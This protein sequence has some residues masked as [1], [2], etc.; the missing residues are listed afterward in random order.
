MSVSPNDSRRSEWHAFLKGM[1]KNVKP[2]AWMKPALVLHLKNVFRIT[3]DEAEQFVDEWMD[4]IH[5][6]V[7]HEHIIFDD[8]PSE[9]L[10][11]ECKNHV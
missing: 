9:L 8:L 5:G 7:L 2:M 1:T 6:H 11:C 4:A 3:E 10:K